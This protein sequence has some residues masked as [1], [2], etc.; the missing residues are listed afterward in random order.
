[1]KSWRLAVSF[2]TIIF[3][4]I[5][6][7]WL[8]IYL[9]HAYYKCHLNFDDFI[10]LVD[11][12]SLQIIHCGFSTSTSTKAKHWIQYRKDNACQQNEY[13]LCCS[14]SLWNYSTSI[15]ITWFTIIVTF[16]KGYLFLFFKKSLLKLVLS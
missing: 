11:S 8:W 9:C 14:V 5:I 1:M 6:H 4:Q 16:R 12:T 15:I 7:L 2:L 3:V 13:R 10:V